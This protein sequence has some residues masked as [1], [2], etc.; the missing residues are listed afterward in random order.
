MI[1]QSMLSGAAFLFTACAL[2]LPLASASAGGWD[3]SDYSGGRGSGWSERFKDRMRGDDDYERRE[4]RAALREMLSDPEGRAE[5]RSLMVEAMHER[6][7][8]GGMSDRWGGRGGDMMDR[9]R[10]RS[11][12]MG[13]GSDCSGR[14]VMR[15]QMRGDG[16]GGM[17]ERFKAGSNRMADRSDDI[18]ELILERLRKNGEVKVLI[19]RIQDRVADSDDDDDDSD[20]DDDGGKL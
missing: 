14:S 1:R 13:S 7:M 6:A 19:A 16:Q 2:C 20:D 8:Q 5:L 3:T 17:R 9:M 4:R 18:R 10:D 12:M 11:G 15:D